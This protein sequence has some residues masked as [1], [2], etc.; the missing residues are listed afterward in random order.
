MRR[1]STALVLGLVVPCVT[2]CVG[3]GDSSKEAPVMVTPSVPPET[4]QKDSM[5]AYLN[6]HPAAKK[7]A[8]PAPK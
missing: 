4:A 5:D 6:S 7:G 2:V 8:A 1:F 3:C